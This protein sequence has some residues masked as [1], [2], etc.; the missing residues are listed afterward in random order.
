MGLTGSTGGQQVR[1]FRSLKQLSPRICA[2]GA[3]RA[4]PPAL[5]T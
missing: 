5:R 3:P 4:L 1:E 2:H